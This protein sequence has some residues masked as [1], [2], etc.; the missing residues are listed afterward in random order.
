MKLDLRHVE[1]EQIRWLIKQLEKAYIP[2]KTELKAGA[3]FA[4]LVAPK[5]IEIE[6]F[7]PLEDY[8][9]AEELIKEWLAKK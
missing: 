9:R 4:K 5:K 8:T 3:T 1:H 7:V 6:V 2:T